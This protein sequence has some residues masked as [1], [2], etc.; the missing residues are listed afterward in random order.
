MKPTASRTRGYAINDCLQVERLRAPVCIAHRSAV[1]NVLLLIS[2]F[3]CL[4]LL[5]NCS[6]L[7]FLLALPLRLQCAFESSRSRCVCSLSAL[8][9]ARRDSAFFLYQSLPSFAA[10]NGAVRD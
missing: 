5:F 10:L 4:D 7:F 1:A 8:A 3:E 2:Q 6:Q 9:S